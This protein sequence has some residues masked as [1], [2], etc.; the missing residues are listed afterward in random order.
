MERTPSIPELLLVPCAIV[1]TYTVVIVQL[2]GSGRIS[3][4]GAAIVA[5]GWA[6]AL[7][8]RARLRSSRLDGLL[9]APARAMR[10]LGRA[11]FGVSA[12]PGA[13]GEDSPYIPREFEGDLTDALLTRTLV[14]L[15]GDRLAGKSRTAFEVLN[16]SEFARYRVLRPAREAHG[17]GPPL[18]ALLTSG[19]LPGWRPYILWLEDL[20]GLL[21]AGLDPRVIERWLAG[22]R[23]GRVAI[24]AITPAA[25]ERIAR[26]NSSAAAPLERALH[27]SIDPAEL[28][29][30]GSVAARYRRTWLQSPSAAKAMR[31]VATWKLL[32]I[33]AWPSVEATLK[34][35]KA[36]GG[37]ECP[38][39]EIEA[40]CRSRDA[41]LRREDD[42]LVADAELITAVDI[43]N[44]GVLDW[45]IVDTFVAR[46]R[47]DPR[48]LLAI[49][50]ALTVRRQ[51]EYAEDALGQASDVAT[52]ETLKSE[53][54]TARVALVEMSQGASGV[55]LGNKGGLDY[56]EPM[57]PDQR[58]LI[59]GLLPEARDDVFDPTSPPETS[60][61]DV[62][63]YRQTLKRAFVRA[64]VLILIDAFAVA[65][66]SIVAL[67]AR[68]FMRGDTAV[69]FDEDLG[70][71]LLAAVPVTVGT[72]AWL[73]LYRADATR[74]QLP[75]L[76][77][78]FSIVSLVVAA[79]V[80][81]PGV[82]MG[83]VSAVVVLYG[84]AVFAGLAL[85]TG[86]DAV[87]R[88]WVRKHTLQRRVLIVGP[89][90][91]ARACAHDLT[92]R[93]GRP[94]QVVGYLS[95]ERIPED[96]FSVGVYDDLESRLLALHIMEVV[97]ADR[98]LGT[99]IKADL[100]SRAHRLGVDARFAAKDEEVILGAVAR[101]EDGEFARVRAALLSPEAIELKRLLDTL[102]I[103]LFMPVWGSFMLMCAAW[104]RYKRPGQP[105][106]V[107]VDRVGLGG[108]GFTMLRLRT[109]T[110]HPN[111]SRG[112]LASGR[113]EEFLERSGLDE[114]PQVFNVL[115]GEM[116]LVG[117]RPITIGEAEAL[118]ID[119]R[120]TLA[121]R[122]GITGPWQVA[123]SSSVSESAMR[124][125]DANYL[126]HWRLVHDI[127]ILART[128]Y[129]VWKRGF[130]LSDTALGEARKR[131]ERE[132]REQRERE[133]AERE[134]RKREEREQR[135]R[136]D[137]GDTQGG[138]EPAEQ[139]S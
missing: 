21:E 115:R 2:A 79:G 56:D 119:Q 5:A 24:A 80:L 30:R 35:T 62:R 132:Q 11:E 104:S 109:R 82:D 12:L 4:A 130:F 69:V 89:R 28:S 13:R 61:G 45:V 137:R 64:G 113:F 6:L 118:S 63:F 88:W 31:V 75:K 112:L 42:R 126:R 121:V 77:A 135:E 66:A 22:G 17:A 58:R 57:G 124:A 108:I 27:V 39:A 47:N 138:G 128:P 90:D 60:R 7:G 46:F 116:S 78:A 65:A 110:M 26:S 76:L 34:L 114:L 92:M 59:E 81:G 85:R 97:I 37:G 50:R 100:V 67:A 18:A 10:R 32:G 25:R 136:E 54:T 40:A 68:A 83:S 87:S 19:I 14:V 117:P 99:K 103:S 51:F 73:G 102:L 84:A 125:T 41:P 15:C 52:D 95:P 8:I 74:A 72:A 123:Q 49:A 105:I 107:P 38:V 9:E 23:R 3:V 20:G 98:T 93:N 70:K 122:P 139:P 44:K 133:R 43:E 131:E 48:A 53:I 94:L 16:R 71:L 36:S 134:Q 111:G 120:R 55:R 86:Y 106:V 96:P 101:L 127:D 1:A 91:E 29:S 129:V 33:D